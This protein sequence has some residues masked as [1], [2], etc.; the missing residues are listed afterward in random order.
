MI[1]TKCAAC[2]A[3]LAHNAPRCVRCH[4]RAFGSNHKLTLS[5]RM[6]FA[7][8][9]FTEP[10]ASRADVLQAVAILED[11]TRG[12][13]RLLGNRSPDTTE[14]LRLL[15]GARMKREDVAAP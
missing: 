13:R 12:L 15:E 7:E 14:A 5:L 11:V 4:V 9:L 10:T 3:P 8:A 6:N 1:L 2:A